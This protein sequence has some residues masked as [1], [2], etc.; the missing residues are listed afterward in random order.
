MNDLHQSIQQKPDK[1][2]KVSTTD[3]GK[4]TD[5]HLKCGSLKGRIPYY[6]QTLRCW[7]YLKPGVS[8]AEIEQIYINAQSS[9][10]MK[11]KNAIKGESDAI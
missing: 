10:S 5:K 4:L 2:T 11:D 1:Q 7:F 6:S 8:F 3:N 9:Y